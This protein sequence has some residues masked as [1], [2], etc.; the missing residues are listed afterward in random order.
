MLNVCGARTSIFANVHFAWSFGLPGATFTVEKASERA[1][2][3]VRVR[4]APRDETAPADGADEEPW[5]D[6]E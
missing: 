2:V 6:M 5:E 4:L 3:D 1:V